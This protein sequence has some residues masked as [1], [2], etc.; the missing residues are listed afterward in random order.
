MW[1][2]LRRGKEGGYKALATIEDNERNYERVQATLARLQAKGYDARIVRLAS[3][4]QDEVLPRTGL[5]SNRRN[6]RAERK[7][8]KTFVKTMAKFERKLQR[9]QENMPLWHPDEGTIET[10]WP[11]TPSSSPEIPDQ[12]DPGSP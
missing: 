5:Q 6:R 4:Y 3:L 9:A 8:Q 7:R 2:R 10:P 12:R 1:L 11:S